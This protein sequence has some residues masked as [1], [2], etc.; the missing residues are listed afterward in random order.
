M[1]IE[2][3]TKL[4]ISLIEDI[5]D[6]S[7]EAGYSI[8]EVYR[9]ESEMDVSFKS[10][11]S[12]LTE[13][14][15]KSNEIIV[16][17]L[18]KLS[19]NLPIISEEFSS[20]PLSERSKWYE[21]WLIDP[22]DGTKEFLNRNGEFTVNIALIR[23]NKPV[24]GVIH[25]PY[26][27]TTYWGSD[28]TEAYILKKS[29]SAPLRV[30]SDSEGI[31]RIVTSRSHPTPV[32]SSI[33]DEIVDYREIVVGSSLKFCFVAS[34]EADCY[35]RFGPTSEWDTAAGDIIAKS[36][37]AEVFDTKGNTLTYNNKSG[38]LNPSFIVTN[39][40][41]TKNRILTILSDLMDKN[42]KFLLSQ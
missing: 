13:A 24:F 34:G 12:P 35:F 9:S 18:K 25:V 33:L 1:G 29:E 19:P 39:S 4:T 7:S 6:I 26:I 11:A 31:M 36:A 21:Y 41:E 22:L 40:L 17:R 15:L 20:I 8:M 30:N 23:Q 38:Y 10:D 27:D 5:I 28:E 16:D 3:K 32:T 42:P 2:E 14:D 37:G